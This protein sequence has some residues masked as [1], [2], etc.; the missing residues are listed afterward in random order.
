MYH[1]ITDLVRGLPFPTSNVTP[2][3][4]RFQLAGL[5]RLGYKPWP[6]RQV[7]QYHVDGRSLPDK[8]FV[9]TFDDGYENNFLEARPILSELGIPATIF[10]C[11]GY[12]DQASPFPFE[13]W[14]LPSFENAPM[15]SWRPLRSEQIATMLDERL[16]EIGTHTHTHQD[17]RNAP[18]RFRSDLMSS[19]ELLQS[20]FGIASLLFAFPYGKTRRG[21]ASPSLINEAK[22]TG[23]GCGLTS[24]NQLT[25]IGDD[26]FTWGRIGV[27]QADGPGSLRAKL[28]GRYERARAILRKAVGR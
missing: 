3:R 12:L 4:F 27:T 10:V 19:V 20:R 15:Q 8:V 9:V 24:D 6:L 13:D 22:L 2:E 23:V 25:N 21:F 1:R 17:F 28:D 26:P 14:E 16:I 11:T 18:D 7:I 5:L